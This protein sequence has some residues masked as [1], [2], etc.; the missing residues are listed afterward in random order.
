MRLEA[1]AA[2]AVYVRFGVDGG[3]HQGLGVITPWCRA[4]GL[5]PRNL[6]VDSAFA[7]PI[8]FGKHHALKLAENRAAFDDGHQDTLPEK[9]RPEMRGGVTAIA[10]RELRGIV[11]VREPVFHNRAEEFHHVIRESCLTLAEEN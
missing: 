9:Q 1:V 11:F 4:R 5:F 2:P 6:D 10:V 7:R 8:E 3:G